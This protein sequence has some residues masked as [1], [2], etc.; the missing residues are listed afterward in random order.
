[1]LVRQWSTVD[2]VRRRM[3]SMA[4]V[5]DWVRR[6]GPGRRPEQGPLYRSIVVLDVTGFGRLPNRTQLLVREVLNTAV[7]AAFRGS[8]VRWSWLAVEDRGDGAIILVPATVS[9]V[10]LLDPVIPN[11]AAMI[12]RHNAAAEPGLR[13][14]LRISVHAGEVHRD[15][16]GWV[17]SDLNVACR[18]VSSAAVCRYLLRRPAVDVLVVVSDAI[19]HGVVRHGYRRISPATYDAV[20]VTIKELSTRAWVHVP[21]P[22]AD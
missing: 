18:L 15:A 16:N 2:D 5:P 11:L 3:R 9:K 17:G 8:G 7:R 12:R 1:M 22:D 20:H 19:Y 4:T 21:E 10:D 14:R 13:I 6:Y